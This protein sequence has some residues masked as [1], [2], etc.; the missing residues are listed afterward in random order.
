MK[1]ILVVL[2]VLLIA[3]SC[4]MPAEKGTPAQQAVIGAVEV[5]GPLR[6]MSPAEIAAMESAAV[7]I[8]ARGPSMVEPLL[9]EIEAVDNPDRRL[10][11]TKILHLAVEGIPSASGREIYHRQIED[12]ARRL[13]GSHQSADRYAGLLLV[14]LPQESRIVSAAIDMLA[15]AD[16]DNRA[17]AISV[18]RLVSGRDFGYRA[19]GSGDE[20]KAA[21][22]R[23]RQWWRK[24]RNSEIYYQP[25]AN[26]ILMGFRAET[27]RITSSAGPYPVSVTDKD[28]NPVPGAVVAYSYSFSTPDG[29]G[30]IIKGREMTDGDGK[31]L[32]SA[33]RVVSGL[34]F[35]G[36][37]LIVSRMGYRKANL[38]IMPHVLTPNGFPVDVKLEKE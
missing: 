20:R 19:D 11:L 7:R 13:L 37:E 34:T 5:D 4:T 24:N 26:P 3:A 28:G 1:R 38:R 8:L 18:L 33:E 10:V 35:M 17:F 14:G 29:V 31:T 12:T 27:S 23:W 25:A 21:L 9:A 15:D 30:K 2:P 16:A 6:E 36:A 22:G 32:T